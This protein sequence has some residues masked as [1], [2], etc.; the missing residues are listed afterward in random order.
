MFY[1]SEKLS[2]L[3]GS[4]RELKR[5]H[6]LL[7]SGKQLGRVDVEFKTVDHREMLGGGHSSHSGK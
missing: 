2:S 4:I 7:K 1:I 6:N 3:G 5:K